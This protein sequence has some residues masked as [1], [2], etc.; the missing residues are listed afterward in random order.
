[1]AGKIVSVWDETEQV[2]LRLGFCPRI[3]LTRAKCEW[4]DPVGSGSD[5]TVVLLL[6]KRVDAKS[7]KPNGY[8]KEKV[9]YKAHTILFLFICILKRLI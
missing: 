8:L 7:L 6:S 3:M 5:R 9:T 2:A 1:M 4:V